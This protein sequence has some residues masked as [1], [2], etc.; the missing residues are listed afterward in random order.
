L[1]G[2]LAGCRP[3]VSQLAAPKPEDGLGMPEPLNEL[4]KSAE[5]MADGPG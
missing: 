2:G 5:D 1:F 4:A 3:T